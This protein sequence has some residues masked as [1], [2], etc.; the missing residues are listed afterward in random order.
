MSA[1]GPSGVAS[2]PN[3]YSADGY[4]GHSIRTGLVLVLVSVPVP[5]PVRSCWLTSRHSQRSTAPY[6]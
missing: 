1:K 2:E 6:Y 3:P 4:H 5:V